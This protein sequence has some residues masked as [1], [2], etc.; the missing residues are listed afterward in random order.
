MGG[1]REVFVQG[2]LTGFTPHS[3]HTSY[4]K[5][6]QGSQAPGLAPSLTHRLLLAALGPR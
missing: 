6:G 3:N 4:S 5:R 2:S 1:P